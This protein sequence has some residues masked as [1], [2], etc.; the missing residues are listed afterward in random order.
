MDQKIKLIADSLGQD[1]VK[2][3]ELVSE[4]S[5]LRVGG[6]AKLFFFAFSEQEI[7]KIFEMCRDLK[8]PFF[9]FGTG[10]KMMISDKGFNGVVVKNRTTGTK[11]VGVKGKVSKTGIGVDEAM[12]EAESGLSISGLLE[13]LEKQGLDGGQLVGLP[14]SIGGNL[15][16]NAALQEKSQG[17]KVIEDGEVIEIKAPELSLRKHIIL[18]AVF[19]FKAKN[20]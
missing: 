8:V 16:I 11:I 6:P 5:A 7:L 19:K 1:R 13:F 4:H 18:S 2:L 3:N 9:I 20:L 15:A 10:S 14:G 17:I 12:I